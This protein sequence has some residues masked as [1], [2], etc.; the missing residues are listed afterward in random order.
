[1]IEDKINAC[2]R[3]FFLEEA[4]I[5]FSNNQFSKINF[6]LSR[7]KIILS[8]NSIESIKFF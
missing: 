8:F 4:K 5:S 3:Y 7:K 6:Q 1:M 2:H